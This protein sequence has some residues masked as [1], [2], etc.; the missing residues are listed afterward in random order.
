MELYFYLKLLFVI[1]FLCK[2]LFSSARLET[3]RFSSTFAAGNNYGDFK[4]LF[5]KTENRN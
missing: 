2:K 3:V 1:S 5:P 4:K